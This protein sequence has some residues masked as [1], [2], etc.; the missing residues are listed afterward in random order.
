MDTSVDITVH[1]ASVSDNDIVMN[2]DEEHIDLPNDDVA[3]DEGYLDFPDD[4]SDNA[5]EDHTDLPNDAALENPNVT[6]DNEEFAPSSYFD[7]A[8]FE[9]DYMG[10]GNEPLSDINEVSPGLYGD[11]YDES[12]IQ[13]REIEIARLEAFNRVREPAEVAAEA[14]AAAS[15]AE[16]AATAATAATTTAAELAAELLRDAETDPVVHPSVAL[17]GVAENDIIDVDSPENTGENNNIF[18]GDDEEY[19][20]P[21]PESFLDFDPCGTAA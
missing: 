14:A 1:T 21:E 20:Q 18:Y 5:D 9:D 3:E 13:R 16:A 19:V 6:D 7:N 11:D 12:I 4:V 15:A 8:Y 10:E 17:A 2:P